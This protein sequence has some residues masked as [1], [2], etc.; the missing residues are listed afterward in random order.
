MDNLFEQLTNIS[1]AHAYDI[2]SEQVKELRADNKILKEALRYLLQSYR[3][4][5]KNITGSELNETEAVKQAKEVIN[6][7]K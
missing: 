3:A 2:L 7:C 5:F 1:K 6:K 4:D